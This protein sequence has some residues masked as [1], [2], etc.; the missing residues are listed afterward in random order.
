[1]PTRAPLASGLTAAI[2]LACAAGAAGGAYVAFKWYEMHC[3]RQI[4]RE[5]IDALVLIARL[6]HGTAVLLCE[7]NPSELAS[8]MQSPLA[9]LALKR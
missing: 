3:K 8:A 9:G 6:V 4:V 2:S 5:G 1:M 7:H